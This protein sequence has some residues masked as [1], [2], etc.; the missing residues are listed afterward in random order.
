[1]SDMFDVLSEK[2]GSRLA[3][4]AEKNEDEKEVI[5]YGF[6]R[7]FKYL[8]WF[9]AVFL[10]SFFLNIIVEAFMSLTTFI[11]IR[12]RLN[13]SHMSNSYACLAYS[14][15]IP[16][17]VAIISRHI[18]INVLIIGIMLTICFIIVK[19]SEFKN[20]DEEYTNSCSK[21]RLIQGKMEALTICYILSMSCLLIYS[22]SISISISIFLSMMY[23]IIDFIICNRNK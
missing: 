11:A 12:H 5:I 16:I 2:I 14:T 23:C 7:L 19:I 8:S 4:I 15:A 3:E 9:L 17:I 21:E 22:C 13:G 18:N 10:F 6:K 20:G 1:M